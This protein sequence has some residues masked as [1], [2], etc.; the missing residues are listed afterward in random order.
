MGELL[1][2]Q[3]RGDAELRTQ[4]RQPT[5]LNSGPQ[6]GS[7]AIRHGPAHSVRHTIDDMLLGKHSIVSGVG[8]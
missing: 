8:R 5:L 6:M 3:I 2:S 7:A 1:G 4:V